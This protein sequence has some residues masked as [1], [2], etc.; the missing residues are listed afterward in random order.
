M[1]HMGA[2][3]KLVHFM[4][5]ENIDILLLSETHVNTNS[6]ETHDKYTFVFSTNVTD[7][8]RAEQEKSLKEAQI[9]KGKTKGKG[10]ANIIGKVNIAAEN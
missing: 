9:N 8:Q 10:K 1:A 4:E 6:T 7:K 2:R 3:E 5:K